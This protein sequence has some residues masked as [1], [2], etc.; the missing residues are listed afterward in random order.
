MIKSRFVLDINRI[1]IIDFTDE[2]KQETIALRR[3][4][5]YKLPDCIVAATSIVLNATLLTSDVRLLRLEWQG[6]NVKDIV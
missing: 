5:R 4:V 2:I 6:F 3:N 1:S